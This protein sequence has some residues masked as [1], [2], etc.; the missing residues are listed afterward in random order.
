MTQ[1]EL[2]ILYNRFMQLSNQEQ[3]LLYQ[4]TDVVCSFALGKGRQEDAQHA[5]ITLE[6][7]DPDN[8]SYLALL[9][10]RRLNVSYSEA[11]YI[12]AAII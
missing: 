8:L 12:Q 6:T 1:G 11:M 4:F 2:A 10:M 7:I 9:S 5:I 3:S